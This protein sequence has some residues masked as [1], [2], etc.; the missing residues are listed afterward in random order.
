MV[1]LISAS[2][3]TTVNSGEEGRTEKGSNEL[4][5]KKENVDTMY[6]F[7]SYH[8]YCLTEAYAFK[9]HISKCQKEKKNKKPY[10]KKRSE[11]NFSF[12][13]ICSQFIQTNQRN[14]FHHNSHHTRS[15]QKELEITLASTTTQRKTTP[16]SSF[17][18]FED[19]KTMT[20]II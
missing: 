13:F 2:N 9:E 1:T 4:D 18:G 11:P 10:S 7:G 5:W 15:N 20:T 17:N 14:H 16:A 6:G 3:C 12:V 19:F 8:E